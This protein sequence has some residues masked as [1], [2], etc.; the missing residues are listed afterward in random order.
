[1]LKQKQ[2]EWDEDLFRTTGSLSH[3]QQ[4]S[5]P[6]G[7]FDL[8]LT[9]S[10]SSFQSNMTSGNTLPLDLFDLPLSTSSSSSSPK[11]N[12]T[13]TVQAN[14]NQDLRTKLTNGD[15]DLT[16]LYTKLNQET[17]AVKDLQ[18]GR[19]QLE[20]QISRAQDMRGMME[21]RLSNLKTQKE[22]ESKTVIDLNSSLASMES[23]MANLRMAIDVSKRELGIA[24][25]DKRSLLKALAE[26]REES[27]ELK[28]DLQRSCDEVVELRKDL[29]ARMRMLG[30]DP[31][32]FPGVPGP[33]PRLGPGGEASPVEVA[34]HNG[35]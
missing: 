34:E 2:I 31:V 4:P 21:Q 28:L 18:T 6:V 5:L 29:E 1:M 32:D 14:D 7:L 30:L 35:V 10:S 25:E 17:K 23:E 3:K 9:T 33:G 26:G 27:L 19:A 8:P 11:T 13:R 20:E 24:Q 15:G 12:K 22:R 16:V